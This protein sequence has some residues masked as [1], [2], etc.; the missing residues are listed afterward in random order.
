MWE[1]H[2][3]NRED[4]SEEFKY[5]SRIKDTGK[6]APV[7]QN[8]IMKEYGTCGGESLRIRTSFRSV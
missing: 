8:N 5:M 4:G 2:K 1:N 7:S 6:F 3:S